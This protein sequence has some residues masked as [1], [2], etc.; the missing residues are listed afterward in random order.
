MPAADA[1]LPDGIDVI[2][3]TEDAGGANLRRLLPARS[4]SG[5]FGHLEASEWRVVLPGVGPAA[6]QRAVAGFL[7]LDEAPVERLT[8]KGVRRLDARAAVVEMNVCSDG[9]D[10]GRS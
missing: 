9:T 3:V 7:T 6:A 8:D 1:A 5:G 4:P 10:H 2:D